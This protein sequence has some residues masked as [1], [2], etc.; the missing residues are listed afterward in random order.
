[1]SFFLFGFDGCISALFLHVKGLA[2][3]SALDFE[4]LPLVEDRLLLYIRYPRTI[5]VKPSK[6][7]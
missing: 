1:M 5:M 4:F 2:L 7:V 3:P 6:I